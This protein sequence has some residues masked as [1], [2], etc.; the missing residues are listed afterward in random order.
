MRNFATNIRKEFSIFIV[1]ATKPFFAES[2]LSSFILKTNVLLLICMK[3]RGC[4]SCRAKT[5]SKT[6]IKQEKGQNPV[7]KNEL[8]S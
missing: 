4:D 5:S 8:I 3:S 1:A 6:L 7:E 2:A